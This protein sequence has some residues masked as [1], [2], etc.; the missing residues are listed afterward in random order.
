MSTMFLE[1]HWTMDSHLISMRGYLA[2]V[3]LENGEILVSG[4]EILHGYETQ[5]I[6]SVEIYSP[7]NRKWRV[8][9]EMLVAR[10]QH[11]L[12]VLQNR[13][14]ILAIGSFNF[15]D[16][17]T[18][19][20]YDIE[21][22]RW[23]YVPSR[24]NIGHYI[25]TATLLNNGQVVT[26]SVSCVSFDMKISVQLYDPSL[27]TF[28]NTG[29]LNTAR[30]SHTATLLNDGLRVL[31]V[32]GH[33]HFSMGLSTSEIYASGSWFYTLGNMITGRRFHTAVLLLNGDVLI[34]GGISQDG[35]ALSS[36]EIYNSETSTFSSTK[37]MICARWGFTMTLLPSGKVLAVGGVYEPTNECLL[38]SELYDPIT[39][40]WTSTRLLN[41]FHKNFATILLNN[42]VLIIGGFNINGTAID[43]CERYDV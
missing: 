38:V 14:R 20:I 12:T 22:N 15:I 11:T 8:A 18:A 34:A 13:K 19:E 39:H 32:G 27:N 24:M 29:S 43:E 36:A 42:S 21:T 23:V 17:Y 35:S 41:T 31:V 9:A 16:A 3:V 28:I 37:S 1:N 40:E 30:C 26:I 33:N 4:G 5:Q 7:L 2:A 6:S 25:H 10:S